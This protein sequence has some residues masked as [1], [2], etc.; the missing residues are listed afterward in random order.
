MESYKNCLEKLNKYQEK[1]NNI[2]S[3]TECIK[4]LELI[5]KIFNIISVVGYCKFIEYEFKN[6][7]EP[8]IKNLIAK[9]ERSSR[10][11][12]NMIKIESIVFKYC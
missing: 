12:L 9:S 1:Y 11:L 10:S 5:I 4:L 8:R 7:L 6:I 2:S 3:N